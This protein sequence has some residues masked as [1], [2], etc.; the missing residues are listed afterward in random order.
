MLICQESSHPS[1]AL[2]FIMEDLTYISRC[3][4]DIGKPVVRM[5]HLWQPF[6]T[7]HEPQKLSKCRPVGWL[8]CKAAHNYRL[9]NNVDILR[10]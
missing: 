4:I 3:S 8:I 2:D 1:E 7:L 5:A 6:K 9:E 10:E